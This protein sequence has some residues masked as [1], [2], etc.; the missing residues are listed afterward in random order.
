MATVSKI[1]SNTGRGIKPAAATPTILYA[2]PVNKQAQCR[3][4]ISNQGGINDAVRVAITPSGGTLAATDY[5]MYDTMI[6]AIGIIRD[7]FEL[8]AGDFVT[9]QSAQGNCSFILT[10]LEVS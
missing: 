10:G 1:L 3:L 2:V 4:L 8:N 6:P 5:I 7:N 9:V